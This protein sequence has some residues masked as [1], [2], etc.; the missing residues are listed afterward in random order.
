MPTTAE[1][2]QWTNG[3][4]VW[5]YDVEHFFTEFYIPGEDAELVYAVAIRVS[6]QAN[7]DTGRNCNLTNKTIAKHCGRETQHVRAALE[8]LE[9][10]GLLSAYQPNGAKANQP[11]WKQIPAGNEPLKRMLVC[12]DHQRT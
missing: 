5:I 6:A 11:N 12:H 7:K 10:L 4:L 8:T 9:D 1:L 3:S 2:P